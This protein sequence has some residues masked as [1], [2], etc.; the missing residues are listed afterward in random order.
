MLLSGE[1]CQGNSFYRFWVIKVKPTEGIKLPPSTQISVKYPNDNRANS[2][3]TWGYCALALKYM[4]SIIFKR[5]RTRSLQLPIF[6]A[7]IFFFQVLCMLLMNRIRIKKKNVSMVMG[8]ITLEIQAS[9]FQ[10]ND[11][12]NGIKFHTWINTIFLI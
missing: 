6:I 8:K 3:I 11:G 4:Q 2:K 1:K 12:F 5:T 9:L 7:S 10:E